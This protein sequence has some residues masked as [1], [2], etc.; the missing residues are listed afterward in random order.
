MPPLSTASQCLGKCRRWDHIWLHLFSLW[1]EQLIRQMGGIQMKKAYEGQ[2]LQGM[3]ACLS[4]L[5][6]SLL[7]A[8]GM[9]RTLTK[10]DGPLLMPRDIYVKPFNLCRHCIMVGVP[11]VSVIHCRCPQSV[12][13]VQGGHDFSARKH[14]CYSSADHWAVA[15]AIGS[16]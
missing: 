5:W 12:L 16:E 15:D 4:N 6:G 10:D 7:T 2:L 1:L 14:K 9:G 3:Q 13:S 11:A 8:K